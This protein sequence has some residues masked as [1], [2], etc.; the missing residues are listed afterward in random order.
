MNAIIS[1][2]PEIVALSEGA[3]S[4]AEIISHAKAL[5]LICYLKYFA[6]IENIPIVSKD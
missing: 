5:P 3:A 6:T 4:S 2:V 1:L